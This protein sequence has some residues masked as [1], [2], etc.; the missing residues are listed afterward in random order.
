MDRAG[1]WL[2]AGAIALAVAFAVLGGSETPNP[3]NRGSAAPAFSLPRVPGAQP[4]TLDDLRGRVVLLNFWATWCKP[5]E[6]E[7][8]AM[9]RLHEALVADGL[10]LVAISVDETE[11]PVESFQQ[12]L[13]LTFPI[14]WDGDQAVAES[15][16][17]YRFPETLLIDRDGVVVERYIG[18]REWDD[19]SYI[20]RIRRLLGG[21]G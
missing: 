13:G 1:P 18:P 11:A 15:Y 2:V 19:P 6:D 3:V 8:P 10:E 14:L 12:R 7:M 9:Q 16:Q 21:T 4:V 20:E 5:C 17:A